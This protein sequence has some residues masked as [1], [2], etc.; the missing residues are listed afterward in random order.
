M[1]LSRGVALLGVKGFLLNY[2]SLFGLLFLTVDAL[3][4][5]WWEGPILAKIQL[6]L[7]Y[8][9]HALSI[10][11][12]CAA[13]FYMW[14]KRKDPLPVAVFAAFGT[15]SIHEWLLD[16]NDVIYFGVGSGI[17]AGYAIVLLGLLGVGFFLSKPYHRKVWLVQGAML[18]SVFLVVGYLNNFTPYVIGSTIDPGV[19]F[20][21][22][23]YFN[24]PVTNGVEVGTWL[25][26][27]SLWFLPRAWFN[28][29]ASPS[30]SRLLNVRHW[31]R[32]RSP[33]SP[34][35]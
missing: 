4:A 27:A 16:I 30:L 35:P 5:S 32:Q 14:L 28:R 11:G 21:A 15:A 9:N 29:L 18:M 10:L 25:L 17:S 3:D 19:P 20:G 12:L 13:A 6:N 7:F 31:L 23:Q 1:D 22:S 33:S 34:N 2:A 26:P 24:N 8:N